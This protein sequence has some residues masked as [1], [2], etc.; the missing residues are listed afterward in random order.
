MNKKKHYYDIIQLNSKALRI[1]HRNILIKL[2]SLNTYKRIRNDIDFIKNYKNNHYYYISG[3]GSLL[4]QN[5]YL[6]VTKRDNNTKIN[7]N[8]FSLFTGRAA[9][10]KELLNPKLL[11]REISEELQLCEKN[12]KR[13]YIEYETLYE[14][15]QTFKKNFNSCQLID[16]LAI[17]NFKLKIINNDK[18][19]FNEKVLLHFSKKNDINLIYIF[20]IN[21]C[22]TNFNYYS[23]DD[24]KIERKVMLVDLKQSNNLLNTYKNPYRLSF[25]N[26]EF[27]E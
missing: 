26:I 12:S 20:N 15:D 27:S 25:E 4:F 17:D 8:K 18:V 19:T 13:N 24:L 9:S 1:N 21:E 16:N 14:A 3:G 11:I 7:P 6:L 22:P 10:F 5:R 2:E 23:S